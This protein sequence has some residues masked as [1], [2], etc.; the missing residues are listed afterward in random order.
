[1]KMERKRLTSSDD[2][3]LPNHE[4]SENYFASDQ[5]STVTGAGPAGDYNY[6]KNSGQICVDSCPI[7]SDDS[8]GDI[9]N[10]ETNIVEA[11]DQA[12]D[13]TAK[14]CEKNVER[15]IATVVCREK[16]GERKSESDVAREMFTTVEVG[17][18]QECDSIK[19]DKNVN[20]MSSKNINENINNTLNTVAEDTVT[21]K[22]SPNKSPGYV[23]KPMPINEPKPILP[24]SKQINLDQTSPTTKSSSSNVVLRNSSEENNNVE[25]RRIV[26]RKLS[27]H[28]EQVTNNNN[29]KDI[30]SNREGNKTKIT[31]DMRLKKCSTSPLSPRIRSK[32]RPST[33]M[34]DKREKFKRSSAVSATPSSD[35]SK[36]SKTFE[37]IDYDEETKEKILQDA[38]KEEEEFLEFVQT[39]DIE[40]PDPIIEAGRET[41][42][43]E[44]SRH[45][46]DSRS[47]LPGS[48]GKENLDSLCRMME[49]IAH[50]KDQNN[51]LNERL[52]Y[53]EVSEN[54]YI[55]SLTFPPLIIDLIQI[56]SRLQ[57]HPPDT[58]PDVR[59]W[60]AE[61]SNDGGTVPAARCRSVGTESQ[62][63]DKIP[64]LEEVSS[65]HLKSKFRKWGKMKEA[66]KWERSPSEQLQPSNLPLSVSPTD[67]R[68]KTDLFQLDDHIYEEANNI[69]R[70]S[71]VDYLNKVESSPTTVR[72]RHSLTNLKD[73]D[74]EDEESKKEQQS[75][76]LKV[77]NFITYNRR[78]SL[79]KKSIDK[80]ETEPL[81][82][83][84]STTSDYEY[85]DDVVNISDIS[86]DQ[87]RDTSRN[88]K[89]KNK[90]PDLVFC[91]PDLYENKGF[92]QSLNSVQTDQNTD[93]HLL[94]PNRGGEETS[95]SLPSSPHAN[96]DD[97][98]FYEENINDDTR[99]TS[100]TDQL[101][102]ST[103]S[104]EIEQVSEIQR[105][106]E[107]LKRSLSEEFNKKMTAW[108]QKKSSRDG[109]CQSVTDESQLSA[110]FRKKLDE[111]QRIKRMDGA[112]PSGAS[113]NNDDVVVQLQQERSQELEFPSFPWH[114]TK[115]KS[116]KTT[117]NKPSSLVKIRARPAEQKTL[118]E[119]DLKPEFKLKVAEWAVQKAMAGH[120][121][122]VSCTEIL[123]Q[124][125][126]SFCLQTTEEISKL[127]PEDFNK[128]YREWEQIKVAKPGDSCNRVESAGE[129]EK[130][131]KKKRKS[132]ERWV[133]KSGKKVKE[134][135]GEINAPEVGTFAWLDKEL[136]KIDREKQR[137][138]RERLKTV[139][140][141]SR[142]L[143]M[144]QALGHQPPAMV[145][146][147]ITVK[148]AAG[149]EFK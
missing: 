140:R 75:T 55:S 80:Q 45:P 81:N 41:N 86:S 62:F 35:S 92:S 85:I 71:S 57:Y 113:L 104:R 93:S 144:R 116:V 143:A 115:E 65:P 34:L 27:S 142:L 97:V 52:H 112:A 32:I 13:L 135:R 74:Q 67:D 128:K 95:H 19:Q 6:D 110:E 139:E 87:R 133:N 83:P 64:K 29:N 94:S 124:E 20:Q 146:K 25:T 109:G 106:Y 134:D 11:G 98:F 42:C 88:R 46:S 56:S 36:S 43:N 23:R 70:S 59:T 77:K 14:N 123:F 76:W 47:Y 38:L 96:T 48:R 53:I 2:T 60:L 100:K 31:E 79:K 82:H 111:W 39:L 63:S 37:F 26:Q 108:G 118:V 136:Q 132:Q 131:M 28:E 68:N 15:D 18:R 50:L 129:H 121:N 130:K 54:I 90:N 22:Q 138:E 3:V 10:V 120:S 105:D 1:M 44:K 72:R 16:I 5:K 127:M 78:E 69:P 122:R 4:K 9:N 17:L 89:G 137:L 101:D 126:Y 33:L 91:N 148:T 40:P 84:V 103:D 7:S 102:V 149:E 49:E 73:A 66:F 141:E 147:E 125:N 21:A 24:K 99:N 58:A 145:K 117:D 51:K 12:P 61:T 8:I 114:K 107:Q 119:E 30:C